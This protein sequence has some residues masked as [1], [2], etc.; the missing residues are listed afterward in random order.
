VRALVKREMIALWVGEEGAVRWHRPAAV[1][2]TGDDSR[3]LGPATGVSTEATEAPKLCGPALVAGH[4]AVRLRRGHPGG[5]GAAGELREDLHV[6]VPP[7]RRL[8]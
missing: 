4:I 5:P 8:V 7:A 6:V 2:A 1:T 3:A